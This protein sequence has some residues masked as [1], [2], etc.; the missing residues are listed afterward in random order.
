MCDFFNLEYLTRF[1][2]GILLII[3]AGLIFYFVFIRHQSIKESRL[4]RIIQRLLPRR[5]AKG[6]QRRD[7]RRIIKEKDT[8]VLDRFDKLIQTCPI[9]D[10]E[11]SITLTEFFDKVA[12]VLSKRL[13]IEHNR[14]CRLLW[15][16]ERESSTV[17]IPGLAIPHLIV[18]GKKI[19]DIVLA[20]CNKG[21]I[22]NEESSPVTRVFILIGTRDERNFHLK[23]LAAIAQIAQDKEFDWKWS[24]ARNIEELRKI[25]LLTE[26]TRLGLK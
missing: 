21:I 10:F 19:F 16:R 6:I 23:A 18:P 1:P 22:F 13:N 8:V 5:L 4:I 11:E 9:L 17:I 14:I 24:K 26:R 2:V 7:L 20:R 12:K 3:L 15:V 25:I